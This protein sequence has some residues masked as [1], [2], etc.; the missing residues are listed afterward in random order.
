MDWMNTRKKELCKE[1]REEG[2]GDEVEELV[3]NNVLPKR[4]KQLDDESADWSNLSGSVTDKR[5]QGFWK[6]QERLV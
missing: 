3:Y 6:N 4:L 5:W 2:A 1:S